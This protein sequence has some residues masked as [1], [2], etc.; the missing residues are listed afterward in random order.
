M[1]EDYHKIDNELFYFFKKIFAYPR[2]INTHLEN[3][4]LMKDRS[5]NPQLRYEKYQPNL[6]QIK[7]KLEQIKIKK[8]GFGEILSKKRD[9]LMDHCNLLMSIG[10]KS[11]TD[12]SINLYGKPS[13]ELIKKSYKLMEMDTTQNGD[14]TKF[15]TVSSIKKILD[16][17]LGY[18]FKWQVKAL[19]MVVG[20][21]FNLSKRVLYINKNRKFSDDDLKRLIV[22][23][24]GT[25]IARAE[26]GKK[27][28]YAI[29]SYGLPN[30]LE[31]EEGLAVYNEKI[32]NLLTNTNLKHYAGRV[33]A[34][35]LALENSFSVTYNEL[36]QYFNKEFA[37]NLALRAKRGLIDTSKKG[38]FTKDY[39]YLKGYYMIKDFVEKGGN[40]KDLYV[41]KIGI[42]HL[43]II[44][45]LL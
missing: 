33:I 18:G 27:Q 31:T 30:Y 14:V 37:W 24:I 26:N 23:E 5:Y 6:A 19:D 2:P 28:K 29:F 4:K 7:E 22:H 3:K 15:N 40:V 42:E 17:L 44:K 34:V 11:F 12:Y 1:L 35:D 36:L 25:H 8:V 9:E 10:T 41:G 21:R 20:A 38:G 13:K 45:E 39:V 43:P 16:S 32:N